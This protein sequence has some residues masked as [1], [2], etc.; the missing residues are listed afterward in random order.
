MPY[1][2]ENIVQADM[3]GTVLSTLKIITNES[4]FDALEPEWNLLFYNANATVYQS[5]EW[6][7][8]WWKYFSKNNYHLNI[9]LF[10]SSSGLVGIAPLFAAELKFGGINIIR[11][12]Q[13]IGR[14][15]SDYVN[16]II[17]PGN[18]QY[19]FERFSNYLASDSVKWDI[20]DVED[21]S[22]DTELFQ[23]LPDIIRKF[24]LRVISYQGNICPRVKLPSTQA[25]L[26]NSMGTASSHNYKRKLKKLQGYYH[27][28]IVL[29][30]NENDDIKKG[31]EDFCDI[32]GA[33]W[34]SLGY[35]SAFDD[36][37]HK[38]FHLEFSKNFARNNWLRLF[39]LKVNDKP[40]AASF[41]FYFNKIIY[42]YQSNAFGSYDVMKCSPGLLLRTHVM[43]EG[44]REGM[45][46]FDYMRGNESYKFIGWNAE[47][48][49][50]YL[51][52]IKPNRMIRRPLFI[53]YLV[54]E[55]IRK[56][57]TRAQRE[58]YEYRRFVITKPRSFT[59][60]LSFINKRVGNLLILGYN[61]IIRYLPI[62]GLRKFELKKEHRFVSTDN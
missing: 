32:H 59:E 54:Y 28:E 23:K 20:F 49:K 9:I 61:F 7:R 42:M 51:L 60:R 21:V 2:A 22:E 44:I 29:Y 52:R 17:K 33:R 24:K 48:K 58:C 27:N 8:T 55:L 3:M 46:T 45:H 62:K 39:I 38:E 56:G 4:E 1:E 6:L 26:M 12:L 18:E 35:P 16:F 53:L 11:R 47:A 31:I 5:F 43:T 19:V 36:A 41:G 25:E 10:Y 34:K 40:V 57:F 30:Q 14:G 37:Q 13:F 15:L 50:N